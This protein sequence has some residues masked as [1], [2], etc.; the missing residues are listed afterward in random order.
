MIWKC[1]G[2][3]P[4]VQQFIGMNFIHANIQQ[5]N[6]LFLKIIRTKKLDSICS[7]VLVS[8]SHYESTIQVFLLLNS[9]FSQIC[10]TIQRPEQQTKSHISLLL[11]NHFGNGVFGKLFF[12]VVINL[13]ETAFLLGWMK[14]S[15]SLCFTIM[16]QTNMLTKHSNIKVCKYSE[17]RSNPCKKRTASLLG[18]C[19][20]RYFKCFI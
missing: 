1:T 19:I 8:L 18:M 11:V 2:L 7:C 14:I 16:W 5:V 13:D 17:Q 20:C 9:L 15:Y 10:K 4:N 12:V 3:L 6:H